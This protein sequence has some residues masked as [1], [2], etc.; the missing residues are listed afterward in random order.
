MICIVTGRFVPVH[1]LSWGH[2]I[3]LFCNKSSN[4]LHSPQ[5]LLWSQTMQGITPILQ[6]WHICWPC[7]NLSP[8]SITWKPCWS[9]ISPTQFGHACSMIFHNHMQ[10]YCIMLLSQMSIIFCLGMPWNYEQL[11]MLLCY[12]D[13]AHMK[14]ATELDH[15]CAP[16]DLLPLLWCHPHLVWLVFEASISTCTCFPSENVLWLVSYIQ[17]SYSPQYEMVRCMPTGCPCKWINQSGSY[18][19]QYKCRA[20]K[21]VILF[22]I[23]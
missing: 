10:Q 15:M 3:V 22:L 13:I 19:Y 20:M 21:R 4:P 1:V 11:F 8:H 23:L 16:H 2:H 17:H 7:T 9:K 12:S 14:E 6:Y 5:H 18:M